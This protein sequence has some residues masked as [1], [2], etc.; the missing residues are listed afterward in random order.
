[1]TYQI[2]LMNNRWAM[3]VLGV[4]GNYRTQSMMS[5]AQMLCDEEEARG[6]PFGEQ[7]L[8][9]EFQRIVWS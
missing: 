1:M 4:R 8:R 2:E 9:Q 6:V 3:A 5:V 7:H